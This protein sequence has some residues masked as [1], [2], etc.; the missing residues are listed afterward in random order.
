MSKLATTSTTVC[1]IFLQMVEAR[2]LFCPVWNRC[3]LGVDESE[4]Q[5]LT[6]TT[7]RWWQGR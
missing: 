6:V 7:Q 2:Q 4:L 3:R 1:T 5:E